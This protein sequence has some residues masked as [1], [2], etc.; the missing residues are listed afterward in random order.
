M[1]VLLTGACG[2][3]AG[4]ILPHLT[5]SHEV[6]LTDIREMPNGGLPFRQADLTDFGQ[7]LDAVQGMEAIVHLAIATPPAVKCDP[8]AR[9]LGDYQRQVI[10][11]NPVSTLHV[12]EAAKQ[13]GVRRVVYASSLTVY[14]GD[15]DRP[16]QREEDLPA[17][18]SLYACSKLFGEFLGGDYHR[19]HGLEVLS[20][21]LGQPYPV[22]GEIDTLWETSL[23]SRATYVAMED[24]ASAILCALQTPV[25]SG[26]FNI[27]SASDSPQFNTGA[28]RTIGY[29]PRGHFSPGGF[30]L[31]P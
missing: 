8:P 3:V 13:S 23:R 29:I 31:E 26:V 22:G 28:A 6:T 9:E 19:N 17:P 11:T 12:F 30:R 25:T 15:R 18:A 1:K 2:T 14:F 21:R 16:R 4:R 27:V 7:T 20:L 10:T 5:A 24:I